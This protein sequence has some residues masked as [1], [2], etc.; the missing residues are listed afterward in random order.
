MAQ[1]VEHL[2]SKHKALRSNPSDIKK[3]I[4]KIEQDLNNVLK[5]RKKKKGK[6]KRSLHNKNQN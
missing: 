3:Q 6:R 2:P 5:V 1:V 4:G